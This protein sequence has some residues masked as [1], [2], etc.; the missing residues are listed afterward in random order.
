MLHD[1]VGVFVSEILLVQS[2]EEFFLVLAGG[3]KQSESRLSAEKRGHVL[4]VFGGGLVPVAVFDHEVGASHFLFIVKG[5][6][7]YVVTRVWLW[8]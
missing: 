3:I 6:S 4:W 1:L 2:V 8:V 7:F 5:G